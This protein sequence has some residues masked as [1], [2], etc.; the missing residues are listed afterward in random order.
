MNRETPLVSIMI[1]NY[2]H[3]HY[4][5]ECIQSALNQTYKNIE[6]IVLDNASTDHSVEI[7]SKYI[8]KGVRI[9][10]NAFNVLNFS[11]R[12]LSEKLANGKYLM[13][14]CADDYILE[15]FVET[16][17]NIMEK[18][19]KV[20]YV[21][22]ERDF[23]TDQNELVELN[24]FYN[25]SFIVEGKKDSPIYMVTTVAHPAQGIFRKAIFDEIDGYDREMDHLNA[26]RA[27]WFY[28]SQNSDYAYIR[29]KMCRIRIGSQ[30]CETYV[31]QV[32]FMHPIMMYLTIKDFAKT[33][34]KTNQYS[35]IEREP[36]AVRKIAEECLTY[37]AGMIM[38]DNW[39]IAEKYMKFSFIIYRDIVNNS[40]YERLT[41][42]ID[43][44]KK[45]QNCLNEVC[46]DRFAARKRNYNPPKGYKEIDIQS[47][48]GVK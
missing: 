30:Q 29:E 43:C 48:R 26:D 23:I 11:Y 4:L 5:D 45:D 42:M 1:P 3:S 20:G 22:G 47:L 15:D 40:Y 28:L 32:N 7:A 33:A 16:A 24:P 38:V 6:I 13:L 44:K 8:N 46:S 2:N 34:K 41:S 10:R 27:L 9:C 12:I 14:L 31:T 21:H 37:A 36:E 18:H 35:V 17:V 39:E 25:C 19:P